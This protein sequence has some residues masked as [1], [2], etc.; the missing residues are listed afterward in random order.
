MPSLQLQARHVL[1]TDTRYIVSRRWHFD[2]LASVLAFPADPS[3]FTSDLVWQEDVAYKQRRQPGVAGPDGAYPVVQYRTAGQLQWNIA[4]RMWKILNGN[5][6]IA[7]TDQ[8]L[9]PRMR[10]LEVALYK[11]KI[12]REILAWHVLNDAA[13]LTQGTTLGAGQRFDD[14]SSVTSDPIAVLQQGAIQIK[15]QTG[16]KVTDALIPEPIMVKLTQHERIMNYLVSKLN[17]SKDRP[18]DGEILEALIGYNLIEKGAIKVTD[19]TFN[20]TNDSP[21]SS[22]EQELVYFSGPTVV[23]FARAIPGGD[24]GIENGFGLGKYLSILKQAFP[25]DDTVQIL[26]GNEGYGVYNF[27]NFELAGGGET[28]QFVDCW[29]AFV[30]N[31]LA[32]YRISGAADP[33]LPEYDGSLS[34]TP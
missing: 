1:R 5:L 25:S 10:N 3:E 14:I 27:P 9:N 21:Y 8:V 13:V 24:A 26:S 28:V 17:L 19:A 34:F 29:G 15:R 7:N 6:E 31:P 12:E 11:S 4:L 20:N 23:M 33:S 32:A 2:N 18:I 22:T 30:Q 16:R